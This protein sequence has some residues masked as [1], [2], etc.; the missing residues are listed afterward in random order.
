MLLTHNNYMQTINVKQFIAALQRVAPAIPNNNVLPITEC[1][2]I[3]DN[4]MTAT[5]TNLTIQA[6][7][8]F[9]GILIVPHKIFL[10]LLGTI[11]AEHAQ[12]YEQ[13]GNMYLVSGLIKHK[14][15]KSYDVSHFP[16]PIAQS[17]TKKL[18]VGESFFGYITNALKCHSEDESFRTHGVYVGD[19]ICAT[20]NNVIYTV[21]KALPCSLH[22]SPLFVRACA[23]MTGAT[24]E[25]NSNF[26]SASDSTAN[27][28][29]KLIDQPYVDISPILQQSTNVVFNLSID[30]A[31]LLHDLQTIE[32]YGHPIRIC[33]FFISKD[34]L[35]INYYNA[36]FDQGS[37]FYIDCKTDLE[38]IEVHFSVPEMIRILSVQPDGMLNFKFNKEVRNPVI[39]AAEANKN[40]ISFILP[41]L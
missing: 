12:L 13:E 41:C 16:L 5:N 34:K 25:H 40:I 33:N 17:E 38:D 15:G 23:G 2:H 10:G 27:V 9:D 29:C 39:I 19:Y 36:D 22:V 26:I 31:K 14:I 24:I 6:K 7:I 30:K 18:E 11:D 3:K 20:N 35:H 28:I 32:V 4:L 21:K 37:D 1:V 8:K